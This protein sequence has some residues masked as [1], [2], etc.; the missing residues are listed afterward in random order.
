MVRRLLAGKAVDGDGRFYDV[1]KALIKPS[2]D[3][4]VPFVVGG[5]SDAA[6]RRAGRLADGWLAT[7]CSARRFGEGVDIAGS[8][9]AEA[10]RPDAMSHHG[11]QLWVGVG[12]DAAE[13]HR[14][15]SAAMERFYRMPFEPFARYTP[16][17]TPAEI[18][19][20]VRPYVEAGAT[21]INLTPVGA[22]RQQELQAVAAVGEA[23]RS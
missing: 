10:G 2:P 8:A 3:P 18:A 7:W 11:L 12:D 19:R 14:H 1:E 13:G 9:A 21:T 4:A 17:G 20:F 5:R 6:L 22:D 23:L 16:C 15:V